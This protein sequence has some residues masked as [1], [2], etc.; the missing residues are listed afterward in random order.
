MYR[1][2]L[3]DDERI[4]KLAIK[5]MI[6]WEALG[7]ELAGTASNG[8]SALQMIEKSKPDIIITDIKMPGMDGVELI[9][10]LKELEFDGEILVLSNY[11]D[12]ELVREAM[13]YGA[14]DYVLKVTVKSEDFSKLLKDMLEKLEKKRGAGKNTNSAENTKRLVRDELL[15]QVFNPEKNDFAAEVRELS[16]LYAINPEDAPVAFAFKADPGELAQMPLKLEDALKSIAEEFL[17]KSRW[18]SILG[19]DRNTVL[20]FI[21]Y[22]QADM[23]MTP[24]YMAERLAELTKTYF[25]IMCGLVYSEPAADYKTLFIHAHKC[26]RIT[27]LFFYEAFSG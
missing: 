11:N 25:N 23:P 10:K 4:V 6:Q 12:F 20:L 9:R 19:A 22:R 15:R 18:Y 8:T 26:I 14:Y 5:S 2:L 24:R 1:A 21:S 17:A 3:V 7:L 16:E 13:R 27:E